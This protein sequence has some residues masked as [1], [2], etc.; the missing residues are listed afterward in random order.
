MKYVFLALFLV[1]SVL[2]LIASFVHKPRYRAMT[3]PFILIFILLYYLVSADTKNPVLIAALI[4]SWL[5]DV[6]LIPKGTKWFVAGGLSF[7]ASHACFIAVYALQMN[8]SA[9]N[10]IPV[11]CISAV[12]IAAVA[13]VF[14]FV[15]PHIK[16][17]ALRGSC[18]FYL[19]CNA[20]MNIF[21]FMLLLSNPCPATAIAYIGAFFFFASD[22]LLFFNDFY[23]K[24]LWRRHFPVM[25][26]YIIAEF[27]ITQGMLMLAQ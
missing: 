4:T 13:V 17:K 2:H 26:T 25:L 16:Q 15:A 1:F 24:T 23:P 20:S 7:M 11:I 27:F 14:R 22:S 8:F 21:A 12:Y 19:I 18:I 3:K 9:V 10:V 5:G 6:L